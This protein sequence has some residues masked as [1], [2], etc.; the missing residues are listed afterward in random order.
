MI[1]ATLLILTSALLGE[2]LSLTCY[3]CIPKFS[4]SCADTQI[5]CP[6]GVC[7]N[8]KTTTYVGSTLQ[9]EMTVKNCSSAQHCVTAS[10][11]FGVSETKINNQCCNT[12]LCNSVRQPEEFKNISNGIACYTCKGEDCS[13]ILNCVDNEDHCIKSTVGTGGQK[14]MMRGCATRSFCMGELSTQLVLSSTIASLSC[15]QGNLCNGARGHTQS[16]LFL[17]PLFSAIYV[18][19]LN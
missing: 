14:V 8:M 1:K 16:P 6:D 5:N 17:G 11:N 18:L 7:S 3:Q 4:L 12:T 9:S 2:V 13:S 19:S 10:V 15:C